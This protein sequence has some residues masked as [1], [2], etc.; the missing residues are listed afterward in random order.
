MQVE[1]DVA[2]SGSTSLGIP[3]P[4]LLPASRTELGMLRVEVAVL[5]E[6]VTAAIPA[7]EMLAKLK[8]VD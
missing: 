3:D 5:R 1:D 7:D 8:Q 4:S 2:R 6:R